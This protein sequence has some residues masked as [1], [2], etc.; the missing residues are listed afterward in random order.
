MID[1]RRRSQFVLAG[2]AIAMLAMLIIGFVFVIGDEPYVE[3]STWEERLVIVRDLLLVIGGPAA[4]LVAIWRG[5]AAD[6]QARAAAD[7]A[8]VA[9]RQNEAS[10]AQVQTA[11]E[12][13]LSAWY[14]KGAEML[15]SEVLAVRIGGI[16]ALASLASRHPDLY[17]HRVSELLAA[18]ARLP[19]TDERTEGE[20]DATENA[21]SRGPQPR[22][23]VQAAVKV[24]GQRTSEQV[25]LDLKETDEPHAPNLRSLEFVGGDMSFY[26]LPC[27]DL[28]DANLRSA[29]LGYADLSESW[30]A[31]ATLA[32]ADL[33]GVNLSKAVVG[34][35][36]LHNAIFSDAD[37]SGTSFDGS[38]L[39][40]AIFAGADLTDA[41]FNQS[42]L[43]GT[44]FGGNASS[45]LA[46]SE[47]VSRHAR[48]LQ[49]T[50]IDQA[51][52]D[53][54]RPPRVAGIIDVV[55]G[56]PL[57]WRSPR[58]DH[59]DEGDDQGLRS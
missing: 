51:C 24:L 1:K 54:T 18:F 31:H 5:S 46:N 10:H 25:A 6:R 40:E 43:T 41:T 30:L 19:T 15:G 32:H 13:M 55:T 42:D 12:G 16:H 50:Q 33:E 52:A 20:N 56:L 36:D 37:L 9:S 45:D 49:Q 14:Q 8:K 3:E 17:Q 27:V 38:D 39:A 47:V 53:P 4:L 7:Q 59:H 57:E 35:A 22:Q 29:S 44:D 48:N 58:C 28:W 2:S 21:G 26:K 34:H 11:Q 23:D